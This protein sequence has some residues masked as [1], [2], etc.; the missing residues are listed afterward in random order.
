MNKHFLGAFP[1]KKYLGYALKLN[2]L[3]YSLTI[4]A[5]KQNMTYSERQS[6]FIFDSICNV[7]VNHMYKLI[8]NYT[9]GTSNT[10]IL[11]IHSY[12]CGLNVP[13]THLFVIGAE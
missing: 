7:T 4:L 1:Q 2:F 12:L 10:V 11:F 9:L 3:I 13:E 8:D 6:L 5:K